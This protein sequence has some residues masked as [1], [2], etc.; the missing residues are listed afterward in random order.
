LSG[1]ANGI[2]SAIVSL[3]LITGGVVM[4][5]KDLVKALSDKMGI[6]KKESG[7]FIDAF[8]EVVTETLAKGDDVKLVGFGTFEVSDRKA[9]KGV[10]PQTRKPIKIPARRVPKFKPGKE[11]KDKVQKTN[12]NSGKKS[13]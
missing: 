8:V 2:L 4:N 13:T 9:R 10:N 11:L 7:D 5:K 12:K 6:T 3:T 1:K